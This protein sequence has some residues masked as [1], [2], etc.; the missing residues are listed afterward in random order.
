MSEHFPAPW[1]V[2]PHS[3]SIYAQ[4]VPK[5]PA[6]VADMRGWGYLTGKGHGA[7]GL[8][9]ALAIE[10]QKANADF[11]V[12]AVNNHDALVETLKLARARIEYLGAVCTNSTHFQANS[13][14]FL[15]RIDGVLSLVG[16]AGATDK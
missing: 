16:T 13:D 1:R 3:F 12:K 2:D 9:E 14:E 10:T 4:D 11:I 6:R 5:G 7:L 15:P 8:P